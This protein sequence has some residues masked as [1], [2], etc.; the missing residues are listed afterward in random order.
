MTEKY[1]A[2]EREPITPDTLNAELNRLLIDATLSHVSPLSREYGSQA[3]KWLNRASE[4]LSR[5]A[6]SG[7]NLDSSFASELTA[8]RNKL[9]AGQNS[10]TAQ[11]AEEIEATG[12]IKR[13]Q[14]EL[15]AGAERQAA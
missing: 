6:I 4:L 14:S 15:S 13:L 3:R 12:F 8:Y 1:L 2:K 7:I 10:Q 9:L 5:V 11:M